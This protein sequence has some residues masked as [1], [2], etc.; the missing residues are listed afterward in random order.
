MGVMQMDSRTA[1]S[2]AFNRFDPKK[3]LSTEDALD[4]YYIPRVPEFTAQLR[5]MLPLIFLGR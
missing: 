4:K 1:F 5:D 2:E 3:A